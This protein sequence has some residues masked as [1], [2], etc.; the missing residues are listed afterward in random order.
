MHHLK[1]SLAQKLGTVPS[2]TEI[3]VKILQRAIKGLNHPDRDYLLGLLR[4]RQ[5][6][7][8]LEWSERPSPQMYDSASTYLVEAQI[9]SLIKKYPFTEAE[10]PDLDPRAAAL[11]KFNASEHRCRRVNQRWKAK[12]G[13]FDPRA[14]LWVYARQYIER[15]IGETPDFD[16]IF[17][18]SDITSGASLGVHGNRTNLARKLL[19]SSW[20]CTPTAR[21]YVIPL[22]WHNSQVRDLILPGQIV[23]YDRSQFSAE[24]KQRIEYVDNNKVDFVPKTA[25]THRAIAIEPFLNGYVQNGVDNFMR[26]RLK[27]RVGIDLSDQSYNRHL[28]REGSLGNGPKWATLDL[29]AAS[30]SI[31]IEFV[32]EVLPPD[33][34]QFLNDIRSRC[35]SIDGEVKTYHK[36]C[37][38]GNGF[39]FPLESLIFAALSYATLAY[40]NYPDPYAFSV[41]GDDIIIGQEAALLL[42]EVLSV[43]GFTLNTEKSFIVGPFR[44]SC[45]A[46]WYLGTDVRPVTLKKPMTDLRHVISFHN[47]TLR[48]EWCED[49][50]IEVRQYLRSLSGGRFLRPGREPGD[51]AF[52]VPLDLAMSCTTV[53]WNRRYQNWQ[54]SEILTKARAD[55]QWDHVDPLSLEDVKWMAIL[56]GA[57]SSQPLSLRY[58]TRATIKKVARQ[59]S[60]TYVPYPKPVWLNGGSVESAALDLA[61]YWYKVLVR[62]FQAG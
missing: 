23:C 16:S 46:D 3:F 56:R 59:Y 55:T 7:K 12:R 33:W 47:S 41:Y 50:F 30:D 44:E 39:C 43:A 13:R 62:K 35:Y 27:N 32:R 52:S 24:V 40:M 21:P 48:S 5:F 36:F 60:D 2:S 31:A 11:K 51:T 18:M 28:A 54:W 61:P 19:A 34:Y 22:L 45:G 6:G 49:F 4:G 37:S 8:L 53:K 25:K 20:S 57:T 15:V 29:S 14:Q 10:V 9:S 42:K 17:S 26:D 38:M 1:Q 58:L